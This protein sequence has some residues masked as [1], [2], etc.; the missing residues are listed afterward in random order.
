MPNVLHLSDIH[1]TPDDRSSNDSIL[2]ALERDLETNVLPEVG[3]IDAVVV[4]GDVTQSAEPAQY[5]EAE[6]FL[7]QLL[8]SLGLETTRLLVVPGNHDVHWPTAAA[9]WHVA[10]SP[11]ADVHPDL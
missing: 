7:R 9:A 3:S 6:T 2:L 4:S 11:P 8:D 10:D 1:R 5:A